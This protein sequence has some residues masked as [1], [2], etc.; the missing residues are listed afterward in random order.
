VSNAHSL[1]AAIVVATVP[2]AAGAAELP[3]AFL[4]TWRIANPSDN[5]CRKDDVKDAAEG[6]MIVTPGAV[7]HYEF[8]CR[9]VAVRRL[10][11]PDASEQDRINV[12]VNSACRGEGMLWSAREIWHTETIGGKRVAVV[13]QLSQT[14][15]RDERGRKQKVPNRITTSIYYPCN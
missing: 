9:I 6:H 2:L 11:P 15:Y 1:L 5:Q 3:P 8:A 7:E 4:G 13:T 10:N 14:N 12:D